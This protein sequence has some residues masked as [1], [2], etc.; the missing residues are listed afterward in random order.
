[1]PKKNPV[2]SFVIQ[3]VSTNNPQA[4][5]GSAKI[6]GQALPDAGTYFLSRSFPL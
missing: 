4:H 1:M 5:P 2:E 6:S 3:L